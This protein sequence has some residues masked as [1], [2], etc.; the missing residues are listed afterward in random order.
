MLA[1]FAQ[2]GHASG[3]CPLLFENW[4]KNSEVSSSR[5]FNF[6]VR[7]AGDCDEF[8]A[9]GAGGALPDGPDGL[10]RNVVRAEVDSVG[11]G[12]NG[13]VASR[14]DEEL[15]SRLPVSRWEFGYDLA[16]ESFQIADGEIFFAQLDV[17]DTA[18]GGFGDLVEESAPARSFIAGE[19]RTVGDVVE[20]H[21]GFAAK[22]VPSLEGRESFLCLPGHTCPG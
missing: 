14:I 7:V 20:K 11:A 15:R 17:I 10:S 22:F 6:C 16:R 3:A 4:S 13:D 9:S 19:L 1:G 5:F 8:A 12:G 2:S 21:C 18:T